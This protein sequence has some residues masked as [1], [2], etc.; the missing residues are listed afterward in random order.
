MCS[1]D[2]GQGGFQDHNPRPMPVQVQALQHLMLHAF[3]VYAKKML[4]EV[5]QVLG[6]D[7]VEGHHRHFHAAAGLHASA[8][9]VGHRFG[10]SAG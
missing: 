6:N 5:R 3:H 1:S 2:L 7:L 9:P 10:D 4:R 8:L